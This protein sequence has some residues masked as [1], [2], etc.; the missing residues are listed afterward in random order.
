MKK[1]IAIISVVCVV[2]A[3]GTAL[4]QSRAFRPQQMPRNVQEFRGPHGMFPASGDFRPDFRR[5]APGARDFRPGHDEGRMPCRR[6][7]FGRRGPAFTPDMPK[8][9][10]EQAA[11]LAKLR[12]DLEEAMTS[13]PVNKEKALEAFAEIQKVRQEIEAWRFKQKL[14]RIEAFQKQRELNRNVPPAPP[15][16]KPEAP[17]E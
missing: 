4:A 15:A 9:I 13:K 10:R 7:E 8:E 16:P 6:E 11:E 2:L 12:V 17:I 1:T 14:E 5:E 3:A